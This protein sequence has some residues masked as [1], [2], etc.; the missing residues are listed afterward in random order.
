[1]DNAY[2]KRINTLVILA[3]LLV[4][5]FLFLRPLLLPIILG[6]IL[7]FIFS[8]V[9]NKLYKLTKLKNLPAFFICASLLLIIILPLW[10]FGPMIIDES[11]K[12]YR[13]SQQLDISAT[14]KTIFPSL[15]AS[16]EFS[17][18]VGSVIRS[19]ITNLTNSLMNY[20]SGMLLNFP[21]LI[22]QAFVV[23]FTLFY[24]LRDKDKM[25][26]YIK[27]LLPFSSEVQKKLFESTRDITFSVLFGYVIMGTVQGLILGI[28][29]F[30]FGIPNPFLLFALA[31]IVGILPIV[32]PPL[33]SVP[34]M[35]F[36]IIGGNTFAAIGILIFTLISSLSDQLFRPLIVSRKTKLPPAF[37]LIGMVGGFLFLG[38]LGFVLGPLVLAY[39]MIIIEVYRN[40]NVPSLLTPEKPNK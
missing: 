10:F 26:G 14:L 38:L 4:L 34:V 21:T 15:F 30:I 33:I 20:L 37:V 31:V 39:L 16:E 8:P 11:I 35:I 29:F 17:Q 9:Y 1:M 22:M 6:F 5:S 13:A 32:G 36:L 27:S 19:F 23:F 24:V 40:K 12:L 28:G 18:E 7:A 3:I 2:F 25:T